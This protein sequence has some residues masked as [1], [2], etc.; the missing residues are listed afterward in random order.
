MSEQKQKYRHAWRCK[1]CAGRFFTVRATE[2]PTGMNPKCPRKSCG[3]R[4]KPSY[5]ADIP[6]D[7]SAGKAPGLIGQNVQV[8]A[9]DV[10]H[11]M[12]MQDAGLTDIRTDIRAGDGVGTAPRLPQHLQA[13]AESFWS[14]PQK[15]QAQRRGKV[16]LSPIFGQRPPQAGPSDQQFKIE[17]GSAIAPILNHRAAGSSPVPPHVIVA[18]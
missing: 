10:A 2:D 17:A 4:S 8:K 1:V 15:K 5:V 12:A 7:I 14:G 3:G 9:F 13:Q 18:G 16:D 6:T 11:E